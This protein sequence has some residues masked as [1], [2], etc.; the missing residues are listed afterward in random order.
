[1]S[2]SPASPSP[3]LGSVLDRIGGIHK[4]MMGKYDAG[5]PM[6]SSSKGTEREIFINEFL[7]VLAPV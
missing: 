3:S 1:M 7:K 2:A 6:S 5:K 4:M